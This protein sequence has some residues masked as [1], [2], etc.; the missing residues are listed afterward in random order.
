MPVA[1][2]TPVERG[3]LFILM[4]EGRPLRESADLKAVYGLTL[5]AS[6]RDKLQRLGLVKTTNKKPFTHA[7]TEKGWQWAKE[8]LS[9]AIPKGQMGMGPLYA[10]LRALRQHIERHDY[11]LKDLFSDG[12]RTDTTARGHVE[13]A[14][15]AEADTALAQALQDMSVFNRAIKRLQEAGPDH[16]SELAK[17]TASASNLVLQSVRQAAR[18]RELSFA[19]EE[20]GETAFD[21]AMHRSDEK[22]KIGTAV[23]IRKAPVIRGPAKLG[24]VVLMGEVDPV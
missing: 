20:G 19:T 21:P 15:W 2:L 12:K 3:A 23:K 8:Q 5:R 18:K 17:R 10:L 6:H 9:A 7:I 16:I 1:E 4:A 24:V 13:N 22:L 14:A 11:T